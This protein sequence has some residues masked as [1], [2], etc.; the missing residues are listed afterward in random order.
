VLLLLRQLLLVAP[1]SLGDVRH[2]VRGDGG[3]SADHPAG[4]GR[5]RRLLQP[6]GLLTVGGDLRGQRGEGEQ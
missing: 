5:R 1:P 3:M 4:G 6:V 2:R